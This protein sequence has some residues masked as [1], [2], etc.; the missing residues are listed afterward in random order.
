VTE[1]A[2][3]R[4]APVPGL[5]GTGYLADDLYLMSHHERSGRPLLSPRAV[6]LGLAGALLAELILAGCVDV[7]AGQLGA[8]GLGQPEDILAARVLG[9]LASEQPPRPVADWLAFL[10]RTAAVDVTGRLERA[11]YLIAAP[12]LPWRPARWRPA[13]PDCAFAP[14]TRVKSAL[15]PGRPAD[16]QDVALAGLAAACGLGARLAA[17]LPAGSRGRMEAAT[18]RLDPGLRELITQTQAAVGAALLAHRI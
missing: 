9:V 12:A 11:G 13:D 7:A 14:V 3:D 18:A 15:C 6:G 2:A 16:A 5:G 8:A 17:Y 10:G 4:R 1:N